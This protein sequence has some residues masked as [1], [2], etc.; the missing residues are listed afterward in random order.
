MFDHGNNKPGK[1]NGMMD[2]V[3]GIQKNVAG[4]VVG[5]GNIVARASGALGATGL[6]NALTGESQ[7]Q[8]KDVKEGPIGA[9]GLA[10]FYTAFGNPT[11]NIAKVD[12]FGT[13][14]CTFE[15]FPNV[16]FQ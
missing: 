15:F 11:K 1:L 2:S 16:F 10:K 12:P 7:I 13:F 5:V 6:A 8:Y 9:S 14:E 4:T 3:S